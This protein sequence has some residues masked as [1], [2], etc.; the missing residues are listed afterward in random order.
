MEKVLCKNCQF[1]EEKLDPAT[2]GNQNGICHANPP[3][4]S[5]IPTSQGPATA[6][7]WPAV[8][9]ADW[10]GKGLEKVTLQ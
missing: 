10:C 9:P 5:I 2:I 1:Y 3:Q 6:V 8:T 7:C 4:A